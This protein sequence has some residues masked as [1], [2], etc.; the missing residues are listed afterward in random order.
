MAVSSYHSRIV[1]FNDVT[2]EAISLNHYIYLFA[3][4][5]DNGDSIHK[6]SSYQ[7]IL[8]NK[9]TEELMCILILSS[10]GQA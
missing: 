10:A 4:T 8:K 1:G 6:S 5:G 3:M 2:P 9:I 7:T